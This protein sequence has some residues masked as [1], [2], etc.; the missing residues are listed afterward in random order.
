MD[1]QLSSLD[2]G[3]VNAHLCH[4]SALS[5]S[6]SE[7]DYVSADNKYLVQ[8]STHKIKV[9]N[10]IGLLTDVTYDMSINVFV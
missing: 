1:E 2:E 6:T 3:E 8:G 9:V 5:E 7:H 4:F 10:V